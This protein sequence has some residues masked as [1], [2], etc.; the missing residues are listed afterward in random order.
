[1]TDQDGPFEIGDDMDEPMIEARSMGMG[2]IGYTKP[3]D[4]AKYGTSLECVVTIG[5]DD[6]L[7]HYR[8]P[9]DQW[10][11]IEHMAHTTGQDL[12]SYDPVEFTLPEKVARAVRA[13]ISHQPAAEEFAR[14]SK[15]L[16][17]ASRAL[18]REE[19][20]AFAAQIERLTTR[21]RDE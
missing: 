1:M 9:A 12:K 4:V 11:H 10:P 20:D 3:E 13:Y 5:T 7:V 19:Q 16:N 8:V 2:V 6:G 17:V 18:N 15:E 14:T 21:W